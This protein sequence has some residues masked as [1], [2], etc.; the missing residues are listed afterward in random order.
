MGRSIRRGRERREREGEGGRGG[1][2]RSMRRE[3]GLGGRERWLSERDTHGVARWREEGVS[4]CWPILEDNAHLT[5]TCPVL[6]C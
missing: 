5:Y 1:R 4:C 3:N 2:D 6:V